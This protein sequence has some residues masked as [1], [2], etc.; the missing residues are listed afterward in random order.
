MGMAE[1]PKSVDNYTP[2][3]I[4]QEAPPDIPT[5]EMSQRQQWNTPDDAESIL[6]NETQP[7]GRPRV[8]EWKEGHGPS[9]ELAGQL[10]D[11]LGSKDAARQLAITPGEVQDLAPRMNPRSL[12]TAAQDRMEQALAG[13]TPEEKLTYLESAP[14]DLA[15]LFIQ[16]RMGQ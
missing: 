14:N 1:S 2:V 12:P 16:T 7:L 13:M 15:K 11:E 5:D 3:D 8:K 6:A 9:P 10:R 4:P